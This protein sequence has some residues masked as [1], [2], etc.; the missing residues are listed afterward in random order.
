VG[1]RQSLDALVLENAIE[2]PSRAAVGIG[3]EDLVEAIGPA[4]PDPITDGA[5]DPAWPVVK[6][7]RQA[8]DLHVREVGSQ[9]D[10]LSAQG[11][12]AD[13]EHAGGGDVRLRHVVRR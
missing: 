7:R 13:H 8:G 10:E 9:G 2:Q 11:S 6:I 5:G 3:D 12:A 4:A 1:P